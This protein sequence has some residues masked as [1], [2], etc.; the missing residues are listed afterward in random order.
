MNPAPTAHLDLVVCEHCDTVCRRVTLERHQ[1][2]RCARCDAVLYRFNRLSVDQWL[3]LTVAAAVA[4]LIANVSPIIRISTQGQFNDSTLLGAVAALSHGWIT[5][6]AVPAAIAV[7][8]VPFLQIASLGWL[9]GYARFGRRAPGFAELMRLLVTLRPWSMVEVLLLGILVS[10]VKLSSSLEV[11]AE[12]GV[13]ATAA[14]TVLIACVASRDVHQLWDVVAPL[15]A[16][17]AHA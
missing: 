3:A 7:I 13:W 5:P 1:V 2:A 10:I 12:A 4:F 6:L 15:P 9:L 16:D 14:L 8:V 17:R 11:T